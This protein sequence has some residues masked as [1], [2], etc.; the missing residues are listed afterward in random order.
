M[1][2]A[3]QATQEILKVTGKESA[4]DEVKTKAG[5]VV[6]QYYDA[7]GSMAKAYAVGLLIDVLEVKYGDYAG[8]I[9]TQLM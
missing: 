6:E 5:K 2:A 3:Q 7:K 9:A 8:R 4:S 1:T